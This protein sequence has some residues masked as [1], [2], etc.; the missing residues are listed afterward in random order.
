MEASPDLDMQQLRQSPPSSKKVCVRIKNDLCWHNKALTV[1]I[2]GLH[3]FPE[4]SGTERNSSVALFYGTEH[5]LKQLDCYW[6]VVIITKRLA[7]K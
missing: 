2:L 7:L 6:G 5:K 4:R 3:Y 1:Q